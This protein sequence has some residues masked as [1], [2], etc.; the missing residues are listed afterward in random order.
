MDHTIGLGCMRLSTVADRDGATSV[1]VIHAALDAGATLI[2]TADAYCHDDADVGHNERL[3]AEALASWTGDRSRIEVAT[4]GGL[5]RP[6]GKW[7]NE[8]RAK[9][10][11]AACDACHAAFMKPHT[12]PQAKPEDFEFD[13][14]SVI[15]K[16]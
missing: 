1:A 5:K 14:E 7:V 13:F 6:G 8:A 2:D 16:E 4:K 11:R 15:P 10:L 9:S 12:P 3:V